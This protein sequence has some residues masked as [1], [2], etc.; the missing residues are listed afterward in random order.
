VATMK[1]NYVVAV[2]GW[3][4]LMAATGALSVRTASAEPRRIEFAQGPT[5]PNPQTEPK[6]VRT[7]I[8][9]TDQI[10]Q[11][12]IEAPVSGCQVEPSQAENQPEQKRIGSA[13]S[14]TTPN[15][16]TEPRRVRTVTVR[17]DQ[18]APTAWNAFTEPKRVPTTVIRP[19]E[20]EQKR[21]KWNP[22]PMVR[23]PTS[24]LFDVNIETPTAATPQANSP[25]Q[26]LTQ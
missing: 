13:Q 1:S 15:V 22:T 7:V 3:V 21:P 6:R 19:D 2:T 10:G 25:A 18:S 12:R 23:A 24:G 16:R 5:A 17:I 14:A 9:R 11:R 8:I 4:A 26:C 20:A